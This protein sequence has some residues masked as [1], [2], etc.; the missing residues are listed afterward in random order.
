MDLK[1]SCT[2]IS[3]CRCSNPNGPGSNWIRKGLKSLI[4]KNAPRWFCSPPERSTMAFWGRGAEFKHPVGVGWNISGGGVIIWQNFWDVAGFGERWGLGWNFHQNI[5][6]SLGIGMPGA[7]EKLPAEQKQARYSSMD[8]W[9]KKMW[10]IHRVEFYSV[11]K[12]LES[13][14]FK[15]AWELQENLWICKSLV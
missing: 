3:L 2:L 13:F 7:R 4:D 12:K 8:E 1:T 5:P 14:F 10:Y 15:E 11:I 6:D 9:I